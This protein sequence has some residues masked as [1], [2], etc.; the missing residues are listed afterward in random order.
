MLLKENVKKA[1]KQKDC[2]KYLPYI[3]A[4]KSTPLL[5]EKNFGKNEKLAYK[6]TPRIREKNLA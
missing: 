5:E 4:Y 2:T 6:S 3:L 1:K